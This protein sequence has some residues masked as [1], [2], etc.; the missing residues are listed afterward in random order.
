[1][2]ISK[3]K[4]VIIKP[5]RIAT[6]QCC[7]TADANPREAGWRQ[8]HYSKRRPHFDS[9]KCQRESFVEIDGQPYCRVHASKIALEMWLTGKL[10][11][12]G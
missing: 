2:T 8:L 1:M 6:P 9:A 7:A 3:L 10:I 5:E 11:K 4:P 12:N